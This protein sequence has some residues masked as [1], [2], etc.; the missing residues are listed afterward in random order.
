MTPGIGEQLPTLEELVNRP[1]WMADA[2]CVGQPIELFIPSRGV[3]ASTMAKARAV[4]S[5]CRVQHECLDYA[6]ANPEMTGV[7]AGTTP[8]RRREIRAGRGVA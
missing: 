2:A 7:W 4:C 3:N 6:N 1:P 8:R 5:S